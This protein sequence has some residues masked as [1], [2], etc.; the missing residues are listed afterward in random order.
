MECLEL[1]SGARLHAAII[2]PGGFLRKIP[3]FFFDKIRQLLPQLWNFFHEVKDLL[4]ENRIWRQRLVSV[5]IITAND[6]IG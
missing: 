1:V 4:L 3:F 6:A 5:G 2:S